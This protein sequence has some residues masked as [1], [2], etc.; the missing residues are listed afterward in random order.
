[1]P[2]PLPVFREAERALDANPSDLV[3]VFNVGESYVA[4]GMNLSKPAGCP[5][6]EKSLRAF[7]RLKH[8]PA[9]QGE[10]GTIEGERVQVAPYR[11]GLDR[12]TKNLRMLAATAPM[13]PTVPW[14]SELVCPESVCR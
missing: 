14:D 10:W 13:C 9:L 5:Y 1:M 2:C 7:Q 6:Y 11:E 8:D 12:H 4:A 3:N